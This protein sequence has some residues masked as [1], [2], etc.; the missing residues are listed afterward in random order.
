MSCELISQDVGT[1]TVGLVALCIMLLRSHSWFK[2]GWSTAGLT[3]GELLPHLALS[4][5]GD[6]TNVT[7]GRCSFEACLL[8][9]PAATV[10]LCLFFHMQ[11]NPWSAR[12][13]VEHE[14]YFF[15][16]PQERPRQSSVWGS[17]PERSEILCYYRKKMKRF[18]LSSQNLKSG[19]QHDFQPLKSRHHILLVL[20]YNNIYIYRALLIILKTPKISFQHCITLYSEEHFC[21]KSINIQLLSLN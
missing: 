1:P 19:M 8:S 3:P 20:N 2:E 14:F 18:V 11:I 15:G 13:S 10:L 21:D 6:L 9:S 17:T 7:R 4:L 16:D 12:A 5:R